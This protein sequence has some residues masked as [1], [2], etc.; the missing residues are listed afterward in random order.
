[1]LKSDETYLKCKH[2]TIIS[3]KMLSQIKCILLKNGF[4]VS[5]P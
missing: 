3:E 1:M 2:L 4:E 5:K